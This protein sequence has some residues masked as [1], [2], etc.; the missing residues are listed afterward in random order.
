[1]EGDLL[2]LTSPSMSDSDRST[3]ITPR[4]LDALQVPDVGV[5]ERRELDRR[6]DVRLLALDNARCIWTRWQTASAD[7][8]SWGGTA[9]ILI[10]SGDT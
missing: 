7:W 4:T 1:M 3:C 10:F 2:L 8:S 5:R 6:D 9:L